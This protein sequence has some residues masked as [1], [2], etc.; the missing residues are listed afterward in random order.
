MPNGVACQGPRLPAPGAVVS[1]RCGTM[2][3]KYLPLPAPH[4]SD[5]DITMFMF[6]SEPPG[7]HGHAVTTIVHFHCFTVAS[8]RVQFIYRLYN[9]YIC[10]YDICRQRGG[11]RESSHRSTEL[12]KCGEAQFQSYHLGGHLTSL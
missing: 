1:W 12:V 5:C 8:A 2:G 11:D 7:Q 3:Q 4:Y 9:M 10:E 6:Y